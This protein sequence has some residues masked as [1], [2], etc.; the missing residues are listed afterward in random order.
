MS[1]RM[2]YRVTWQLLILLM[3]ALAVTSGIVRPFVAIPF[4]LIAF[5]L[6]TSYGGNLGQRRRTLTY[7][8][9][10]AL[11]L[12][13]I[14]QITRLQGFDDVAEIMLELISGFLPLTLLNYDRP[15]SYWLG[16]LNVAVIAVSSISLSS[17]PLAY[18]GFLLFVGV[19]LF[20][21]NA[22]DLYLPNANVPRLEEDLPRGYFRQF[23]QAMPIGLVSAA[24]IFV[25]FPR[26]QSF[27][28]SLGKLM[29]QNKSGYSGIVSLAGDGAIETSSAL[30]F[31]V[32]SPDKAW[33][34]KAGPGLLFRGDSL[35]TFDG[36]NW[37]TANFSFK[38]KEQ[39]KEL[40]VALEHADDVEDLTVHMEPTP[41][42][43][44]FYPEVLVDVLWKSRNT[45][46]ILVN[47][48]GSVIRDAFEVERFSY[49]VRTATRKRVAEVSSET[50]AAIAEAEHAPESVAVPP[51][52]KNAA[53]FKAWVAE[54]GI[55]PE[56]DT[57]ASA[58]E[59]IYA[60]FQTK[61]K[62]SLAN[63]FQGKD[64]LEGFLTKDRR[65]HCEYFA[66]STALLL[67]TLGVPARV[68]VGY[69]G[70]TYN[71][72]I[73]VLEVREEN[74]H[75]WV[76]AQVP[77]K[78]WYALDPTPPAPFT[79]SL[80]QSVRLYANA[81][82]FWFRKY[83]VD[84]DQS[85]QRELIR[86]IRSLASREERERTDWGEELKR[87]A[88]PLGG[89]LAVVIV[90]GLLTRR[91]RRG[92]GTGLP[93]YYAKLVEKLKAAGYERKPG[94]TLA[95]FHAR[96]LSDGVA[97]ETV[98][99]VAAAIERDL[100]APEPLATAERAKLEAMVSATSVMAGQR[101][102]RT[103]S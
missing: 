91:R 64:A 67:R 84:Y 59:A 57:L 70:G 6:V 50:I 102:P 52:L 69:K 18:G 19:L 87:Y 48:G 40:R 4:Y 45:G 100:Y 49:T 58:E 63:E 8:I 43:T 53:W 25:A 96:L 39:A 78:G 51:A 93:A 79:P 88:G 99:P 94:E 55:D 89:G 60:H 7:G 85:T 41:L 61:F 83:V 11:F 65:G 95:V 72:L 22:A 31:L 21:L 71:P 74:A 82:A 35:E 75:A 9:G 38:P 80:A 76:E 90:L 47:T 62:A 37:S 16:V 44:I 33:L 97:P 24:V 14:N 54:V 20:N 92:R 68:V 101:P 73:D 30:A 29:G 36:V 1:A 17:S 56:T 34:R 77:G 98:A 15:R 66:T 13:A 12:L 46:N 32:E 28:M 10:T 5:F 86:S 42:A 81:L 23:L 27:S 3:G 2:Y 26:A 103:A